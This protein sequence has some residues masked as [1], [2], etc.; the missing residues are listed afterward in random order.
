MKRFLKLLTF[1]ILVISASSLLTEEEYT[2]IT[3]HNI[4]ETL[5]YNEYVEVFKNKANWGENKGLS[6]E[7]HLAIAKSYHQEYENKK[8]NEG[9]DKEF[10]KEEILGRQLQPLPLEWDWRKA[11]PDCFTKYPIK[12]QA[13]CGSCF[14]FATTYVLAKRFCINEKNKS[15]LYNLDLSPQDL[16]ECDYRHS[17]CQGG[18]LPHT[19]EYLES[20]GVVLESCKPYYSGREPPY[21]GSCKQFCENWRLSYTKYKARKYTMVTKYSEEDIK[22]EI[23]F[24]GPVSSFVEAYGDLATYKGGIYRRSPY[25]RSDPEG[26]AISLI[27]WGYDAVQRTN[28]WIVANSWGSGWGEGGYFRIPFGECKIAIFAIASDPEIY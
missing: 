20:T 12:D 8:A 24:R 26:H 14:S 6:A 5:S 23:R 16:L 21:V 17:K 10:L 18:V 19:W 25:D 7:E 22:K 1:T 28:Y 15:G 2:A 27:G 3:S 11:N 4:F 9:V 13:Y